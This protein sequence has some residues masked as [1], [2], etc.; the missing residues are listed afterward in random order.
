MDPKNV[1]KYSYYTTFTTSIFL[2]AKEL[3]KSMPAFYNKVY[4]SIKFAKALWGSDTEEAFNN[5]TLLADA[6]DLAILRQIIKTNFLYIS[7]WDSTKFTDKGDYGFSFI[8]GNIKYIILPFTE[9]DEGYMIRSYDVDTGNCYDT[10]ITCDKELFLDATMNSSGEII[11]IADFSLEYMTDANTTVEKAPKK[12]Q[13]QAMATYT[14]QSGY[15]FVNLI[16]ILLLSIVSAATVYIS[17]YIV[18]HLS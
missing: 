18:S 14:P 12:A 11:R 2:G 5:V 16:A 3:L 1:K 17:Y 15:A 9:F 6:K 10:K 7:D 4:F 13:Q 8:A